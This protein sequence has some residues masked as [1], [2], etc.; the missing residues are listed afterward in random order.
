MISVIIPIYNV[1]KYLTQCLDSVV[2]QTYKNLEIILINDGSTDKSGDICDQYKHKDSRITVI[3]KKN[4]GAADS[5]NFG[6][7][8]AN[9][10]FIS[11]VDSDDYLDLNFYEIMINNIDNADIVQC[12]EFVFNTINISAAEKINSGVY[13]NIEFMKIYLDNW[14]CALLH[15][16]LF[17]R[18]VIKDKF[19]KSNI[20][21]DEYF[22]YKCVLNAKY[23]KQID[24]TLYYY[25]IRKSSLMRN[26]KTIFLQNFDRID[27]L[28]KRFMYLKSFKELRK[29][30][31]EDITNNYLL[32]LKDYYISETLIKNIKKKLLILL[33][34]CREWLYFKIII[35]SVLKPSK[36][37][38][39]NKVSL[40]ENNT[41]NESENGYE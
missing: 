15:N 3:H 39:K 28:Y 40:Q 20:I 22:T 26:E 34:F 23:I 18:C 29:K 38:L 36:M 6:L 35:I 21:D 33:F 2:N 25:R 37:Y 32:M 19:Y 17:R 4:S 1:Q 5:R 30:A 24:N 10:E 31:Y 16:K 7:K 9:G 12:N 13:N 11:F 14:V 8:I 27:F 41:K